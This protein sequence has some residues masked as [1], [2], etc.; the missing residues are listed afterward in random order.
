MDL[1]R[2]SEGKTRSE[3]SAGSKSIQEDLWEE[4]SER[5]KD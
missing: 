4:T 3:M 1:R 2:D 5:A